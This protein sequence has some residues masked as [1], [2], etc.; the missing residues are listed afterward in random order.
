[1]VKW[2]GKIQIIE[3]QRE[4]YLCKKKAERTSEKYQK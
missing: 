2:D 3:R 1:M 4:F